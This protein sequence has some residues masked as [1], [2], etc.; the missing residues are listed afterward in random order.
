[1]TSYTPPAYPW[2]TPCF[3]RSEL[4]AQAGAP[5]AAAEE[6]AGVTAGVLPLLDAAPEAGAA[7]A[8]ADVAPDEAGWLLLD[9]AHPATVARQASAATAAASRL[10]R[11]R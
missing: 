11:V 6:D 2:A 1:M 5:A 7:G 10:A 4:V 9:D 3:T 8:E